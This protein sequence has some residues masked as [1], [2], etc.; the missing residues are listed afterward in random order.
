MKDAPSQAQMTDASN[1]GRGEPNY[2]DDSVE[3]P[4]NSFYP[5][6]GDDAPAY[7]ASNPRYW[8]YR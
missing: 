8:E 7:V 3:S 2:V 5:N 6:R 1:A 4:R